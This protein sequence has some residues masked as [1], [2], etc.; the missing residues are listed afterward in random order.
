MR[1][2]EEREVIQDNEHGFTKGR[3]CMTSLVRGCKEEGNTL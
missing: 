2:M 3:S 1:H